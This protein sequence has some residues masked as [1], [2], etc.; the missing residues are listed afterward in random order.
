MPSIFTEVTASGADVDVSFDE[1]NVLFVQ[2]VLNVVVSEFDD[3]MMS[4]G[5]LMSG[6]VGDHQR[7]ACEDQ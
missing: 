5:G 3:F 4:Q 2:P 7:T 1:L 6:T